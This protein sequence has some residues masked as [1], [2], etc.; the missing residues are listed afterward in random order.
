[1]QTEGQGIQDKKEVFTKIQE[2]T[3]FFVSS[4]RRE[5]SIAIKLLYYE[6]Q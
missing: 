1:M 5:C 3:K 4:R 6:I 2:C